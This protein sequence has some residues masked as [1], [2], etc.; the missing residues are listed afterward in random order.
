MRFYD[1]QVVFQEVPGQI[2]LCFNISG[3]PLRCEGCHSPYLWKKNNGEKL[4]DEYFKKI[5]KKYKGYA[6]CVL[7]MGGEWHLSELKSKLKIA[8]SQ[9]FFT[10]LY[11][12]ENK[13]NNELLNLL[14]W[15]K[16][17]PWINSRGGLDNSKTNQRFVQI[18]NNK[19][20]NNLFIKKHAL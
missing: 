12:G 2:S 9:G 19:T 20:L 13:I 18:K 17:G 8:K 4:T 11:T 3:C 7:F 10:C 1:F 6:T 5:L 14:T 15:V 16:L